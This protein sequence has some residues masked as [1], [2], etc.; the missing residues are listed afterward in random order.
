MKISLVDASLVSTSQRSSD[1]FGNVLCMIIS[2]YA[3]I[4]PRGHNPGTPYRHTGIHNAKF[5]EMTSHSPPISSHT[6]K[7]RPMPD[8]RFT[9]SAKRSRL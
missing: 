4:C 9:H 8:F 3:Q 6:I 2:R 5:D 1:V 7:V